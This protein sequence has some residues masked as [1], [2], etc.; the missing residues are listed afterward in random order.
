MDI[1]LCECGN[2]L[3]RDPISLTRV[4]YE[5]V[6][7]VAGRF[8][9]AVYDENPEIDLVFSENARKAVVNKFSAAGRV[10]WAMDPR[11]ERPR[12]PGGGVEPELG[13]ERS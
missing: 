9:I 8:A 12:T 13:A 11:R 3:C 7:F 2:A 6:R 10:A 5:A 4:E 1:Y